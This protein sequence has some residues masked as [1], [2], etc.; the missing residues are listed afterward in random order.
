MMNTRAALV[1]SVILAA[2]ASAQNAIVDFAFNN[3]SASF[4]RNASTLVAV[5][6]D[7]GTIRTSGNV[8]RLVG[9]TGT[10]NFDA[11]TAIGAVNLNLTVSGIGASSA[12][13]AGTLTLRDPQGDTITATVSGTFVN[14]GSAVFFNGLLSNVFLNPISTDGQFNGGSGGS[15]PLNIAP[16]AGPPPY[17]GAVVYLE[18]GSA[19]NFFASSFAGSVTQV[20]GA[21]V[22]A[23][24]AL[25]ALGAGLVIAGRR[26]RR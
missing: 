10:A 13:G 11:G 3:T 4:D 24:G 22:P 17:T 8:R 12:L 7:N 26:R 9:A 6:I 21:I 15:F 19:G 25:A 20:S 1:G 2:G 14:G 5:G 18:L 23:P 16:V